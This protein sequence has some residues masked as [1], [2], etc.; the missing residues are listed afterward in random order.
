M[1]HL[2]Q[3]DMCGILELEYKEGT[4]IWKLIRMNQAVL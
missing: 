4:G 2:F 3:V 1:R